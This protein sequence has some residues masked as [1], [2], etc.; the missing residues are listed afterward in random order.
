MAFQ[1]LRLAAE[2]VSCIRGDRIVLD[3]LSFMCDAHSPLI[4]RGPNGAGKSTLLRAIAGLVSLS[5][6]FIRMR[7]DHLS[8]DDG[9]SLDHVHYVG[10]ADGV[11]SVLS[12]RENL[13]FWAALLGEGEV[14]PIERALA[15]FDLGAV[16]D[17]PAQFL[18]AGQ[19]R[20]V[21]LARLVV[22]ERALWLLDEPTA[23][24]DARAIENLMALMSAHSKSGGLLMVASHDALDI[25][26]A[27]ALELSLY[28]GGSDQ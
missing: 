26:G 14:E 5:H 1:N 24:L 22:S 19:R 10:H 9:I 8:Q 12:V 15:A 18:S 11:K 20:R 28:Q 7:G 23:S 6:G 17:L 4:V 2:E 16:A 13:A 27:Q 21:A 3:H 25:P